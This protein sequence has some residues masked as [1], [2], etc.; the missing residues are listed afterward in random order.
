MRKSNESYIDDLYYH[1]MYYQAACWK[2][3]QSVDCE[4]KKLKS[5][6]A[7]LVALKDNIHMR[8]IGLGW[9]DLATPWS[10]NGI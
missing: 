8:V 3:S 1:D 6:S 10:K 9:E 2:T 5:K 4:L 7:K